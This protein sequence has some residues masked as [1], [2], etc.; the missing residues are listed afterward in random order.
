M[1]PS[2]TMYDAVPSTS[3]RGTAPPPAETDP[4]VEKFL[5]MLKEYL[6]SAYI[7]DVRKHS[8]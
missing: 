5:P 4:E 2:F 8:D 7:L 1:H 6:K 3:S